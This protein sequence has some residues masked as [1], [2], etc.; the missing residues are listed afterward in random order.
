MNEK[1]MRLLE[2]IKNA[3]RTMSEYEKDCLR[4]YAETLESFIAKFDKSTPENQKYICAIQQTLIFAQAQEATEVLECLKKF[5]QA[6]K[7]DILVLMQSLRF[8][9]TNTITD[10]GMQIT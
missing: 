7:E 9:K 2:T 1:E 6:E 4:E 10:Y 8:V 5:T 3:M